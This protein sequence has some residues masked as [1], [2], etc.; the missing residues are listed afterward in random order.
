M[1]HRL[2]ILCE[3]AM[4]AATAIRHHLIVVVRNVADFL[5]F[6]AEVFNPFEAKIQR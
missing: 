1:H 2:D 3:D 4:I 5:Q 6:G